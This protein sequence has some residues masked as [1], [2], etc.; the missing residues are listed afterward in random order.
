MFRTMHAISKELH[1]KTVPEGIET[2]KQGEFPRRH[3][4]EFLQGFRFRHPVL[5]NKRGRYTKRRN[6][7]YWVLG[8]LL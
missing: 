8:C 4:V 5:A 2:A 3:S 7:S 6:F 1:L